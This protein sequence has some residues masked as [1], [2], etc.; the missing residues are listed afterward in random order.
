MLQFILYFLTILNPF[1]LFIYTL[2]I[3]KD[4]GLKEYINILARASLISF[5]IYAIFSLSGEALFTGFFQVNFESFRI[6]G[7]IV[8]LSYAIIFLVQGRK[9]MVNTRGE[10]NVIASEVALPFIVG[11][12]TITLSILMGR[13][14]GGLKS[15]IAIAITL[16]L[17]FLIVILLATIRH[18]MRNKHKIVLD[19]NL[20]IILRLNGFVFGT[21]GVDLIL[22]GIS[23]TFLS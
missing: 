13:N 20:D 23:N 8:L 1:A 19:Q 15:I 7:G 3:K 5:I 21:F 10:L 12:G 2:P 17:N 14:L 6:F 9:S 4:H 22:S 18:G 11:A 16:M